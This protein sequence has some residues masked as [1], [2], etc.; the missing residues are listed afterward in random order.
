[1]IHIEKI[2]GASAGRLCHTLTADLPN[3]FGLPE[4]NAHYAQGV[5]VRTNFAA[6]KGED[7]IGLISIDFPYPNNANIYW[8]AVLKN[9]HRQGVG[10]QLIHAASLFAKREG[11]KT[12]SVETL[13][14]AESDENYYKTY[15]F[16]QSMGFSPLLDLKPEGYEWKMAYMVKNLENPVQMNKAISLKALELSDIPVIVNSFKKANWQKPTSLFQAYYQEQQRLERVVWLGYL[17]GQFTGYITLKWVSLY[18]PFE[19]QNIPELMDLNVLP[20]FR[21]SGIGSTLLQIAEEKAA[22]QSDVVGIGVGLYGGLDG[23]YGQAQRL[24]IK[25]GYHPN[26]L[27]VTYD[28]KPAVPGQVYPLDDDLILWFI[29]NL[30]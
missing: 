30:K 27:G 26:G 17:E 18:E 12:I 9:F 22:T 8:M 10:Q 25:H 23:G 11:A 1:M 4:A 5:K 20:N 7:C 24:Y 15:Q 16:Y 3:Y 19:K 21:Q 2:S 29:K 13:S 14:P 6:K 28:Y